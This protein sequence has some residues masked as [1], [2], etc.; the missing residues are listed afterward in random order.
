M[1]NRSR[2]IHKK[3]KN[4]DFCQNAIYII[5][6]TIFNTYINIILGTMNASIF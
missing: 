5:F 1:K 4:R 2:K 6:L 3:K